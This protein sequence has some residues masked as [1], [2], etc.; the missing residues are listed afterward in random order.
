VRALRA[1]P[2][3]LR[4]FQGRS[5]TPGGTAT[6]GSVRCNDVGVGS[7]VG[8]GMGVTF[9]SV[10]GAAETSRLVGSFSFIAQADTS[11]PMRATPL[12]RKER[13]EN[14]DRSLRRAPVS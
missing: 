12:A 6:G 13:I 8:A 11:A 10:A 7:G 5:S 14:G 2:N 9:A 4:R 1:T 3:H